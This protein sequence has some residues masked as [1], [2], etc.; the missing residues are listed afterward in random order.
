M[1]TKVKNR[2]GEFTVFV[3]PDPH[4]VNETDAIY[5]VQVINENRLAAG[6]LTVGVSTDGITREEAVTLYR[7]T[8]TA[9]NPEAYLRAAIRRNK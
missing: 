3:D 5:S 2:Q 6:E 7:R 1:E 9:D 4:R 8:S